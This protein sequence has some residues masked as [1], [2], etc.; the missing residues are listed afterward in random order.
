[1][2]TTTA[3]TTRTITSAAA[4]NYKKY[5]GNWSKRGR[6]TNLNKKKI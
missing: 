4:T 3:A 1:M 6:K 2:T 5:R